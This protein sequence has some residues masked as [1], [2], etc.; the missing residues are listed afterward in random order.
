MPQLILA[1]T[2]KSRE[3]LL[4]RL[5]LPFI[6]CCAPV[7]EMPHPEESASEL[8]QRLSL[9]KARAAVTY[10]PNALIIGADQTTCIQ[11]KFLSKPG[12]FEIAKQQLMQCSG[13]HVKF[14]TGVCL[15]D[16]ST[17]KYQ[18]ADVPTQV[19]FRQLKFDE[20]ERYIKQEPAYDCAGSF[21]SEEYGISL[22]KSISSKDPSALQGLPLIT[23]CRMLRA[24]GWKIP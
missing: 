9:E 12:N 20:I 10:Y 16:A 5:N 14:H 1:S 17:G 7:D 13:R 22:F 19:H 8:V 24:M 3:I 6:V 18:L 23:I 4:S 11:K 2:S 21:R 15:L